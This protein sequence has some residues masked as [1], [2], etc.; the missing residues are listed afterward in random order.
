MEV[1]HH[2]HTAR[3][4]WSHYF[5]EFLMLFLAVF[6][7]FLAEY[8][9]EH[10]IEKD[11]EKEYIH[12][13]LQDFEYDTLQYGKTVAKIEIKIPFYDSVLHFLKDPGVNGGKLPFRFYSQTN[14]EVIYQPLEPTLL[15]L[16]GSGNL[17][18]IRKRRVL[19]SILIYDSRVNGNYR[20][21]TQYVV[22][23]NKRL[24]E[25]E[26]K[27]FDNAPFNLFL[28]DLIQDNE[29]PDPASYDL[30]I[31]AQNQDR[32]LEMHNI[33]IN[34]KATDVFYIQLLMTMKKEATKLIQLIRK[35][36]Q[37]H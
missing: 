12:S 29:R 5:W 28:N 34:A 27:V 35:E 20:N 30:P 21:Q 22:D 6:C 15:Q 33:Y 3:K 32:L 37:I 36:Y 23:F 26:E 17:R 18:L 2:A 31:A 24:I 11:R 1:H 7:G 19:D 25:T 14:I 10:K 13:L 4:K 9:L 8:Q 16:K